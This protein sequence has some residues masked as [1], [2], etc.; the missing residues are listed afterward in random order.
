[1]E[2]YRTIYTIVMLCVS[3]DVAWTK[4]QYSREADLL[5]LSEYHI[6]KHLTGVEA[7][8]TGHRQCE[9]T[10]AQRALPGTHYSV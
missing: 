7:Q 4:W 2:V 10:N 6:N 8:A 3:C 1:M 9:S 5:T